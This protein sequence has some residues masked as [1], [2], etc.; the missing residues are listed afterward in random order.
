[1]TE[2]KRQKILSKLMLQYDFD[3]KGLFGVQ[4]LQRYVKKNSLIVAKAIECIRVGNFHY[5]KSKGVI[6][7][8]Y[9]TYDCNSGMLF[10]N[11]KKT[12]VG[13]ILLRRIMEYLNT[14]TGIASWK[15]FIETSKILDKDYLERHPNALFRWAKKEELDNLVDT[16]WNTVYEKLDN[17]DFY[18]SEAEGYILSRRERGKS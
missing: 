9:Q 4:P 13:D 6:Y 8:R 12:E 5:R 1:M 16:V 15:G 14:F 11:V 7:S 10:V 17:M 2:E 18:I 3:E